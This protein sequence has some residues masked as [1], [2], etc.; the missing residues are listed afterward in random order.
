M[1]IFNLGSSYLTVSSLTWFMN[2]AFQ[3]P[4]QYC[5]FQY[6]ALLSPPDTSKLSGVSSLAQPLHFSGA[7]GNCPCSSSVA[8]WIPSNL[9]GSCSGGLSFCFFILLMGRDTGGVVFPSPVDHILSEVFTM[10][11]LSWVTYFTWLI[12]SLSYASLSPRQ[13]C[14]LCSCCCHSLSHA[15]LFAT[16]WTSAY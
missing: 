4:G 8:Y 3:V 7:V 15:Q 2:L 12:T 14:D 16:P 10:I 6:R 9:W 13:G 5:S 1:L 11:C